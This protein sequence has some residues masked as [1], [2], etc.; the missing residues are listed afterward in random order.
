MGLRFLL[1][2]GCLGKKAVSR[3]ET[4]KIEESANNIKNRCIK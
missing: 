1:N 2:T 4:E 3:A